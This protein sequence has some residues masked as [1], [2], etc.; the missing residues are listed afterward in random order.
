M[1]GRR[2]RAVSGAFVFLLL[3]IFAVFATL[4]VL[5]G[6]R[7]YHANVDRSEQHSAARVLENYLVNAVRAD[8]AAGA[9]GVMHIDGMDALHIAY[10]FDG[11]AYVK[12]VYCSEGAV[13]ELFVSEEFGFDASSG[14]AVCEAQAMTL[15][16]EG[17]LITATITDADGRD[18]RAC[19][20]L[21][22]PA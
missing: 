17:G 3:G 12:W 1:I 8:D 9:V 6:A 10:D 18:H 5:L 22:C 21:R 14:E 19:I 20:A 7:A 11:E 4:L 16:A 13:R 15:Q 2:G